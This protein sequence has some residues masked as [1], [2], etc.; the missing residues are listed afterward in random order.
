MCSL[1]CG[2]ILFIDFIVLFYN[3]ILSFCCYYFTFVVIYFE[4][5]STKNI[6]C[7]GFCFIAFYRTLSGKVTITS[8]NISQG[9]FS[10]PELVYPHSTEILSFGD[11]IPSIPTCTLSRK[12]IFYTIFQNSL[13]MC[14][15]HILP[16][17]LNLLYIICQLMHLFT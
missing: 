6:I 12:N 9:K 1:C 2:H 11:S 7:F 17:N 16:W 10:S 8:R 14:F 3:C 5:M 15:V 4:W 13:N